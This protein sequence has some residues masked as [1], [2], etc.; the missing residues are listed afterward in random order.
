[1]RR[2]RAPGFTETTVTAA[3][4]SVTVVQRHGEAPWTLIPTMMSTTTNLPSESR[5]LYYHTLIDGF[6]FFLKESSE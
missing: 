5:N 4:H 6:F 2:E 3:P 1:M